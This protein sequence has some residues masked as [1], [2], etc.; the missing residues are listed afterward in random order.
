MNIAVTRRLPARALARLAELG[1]LWVWPQD[2]EMTRGELLTEALEAEVMVP[3][4]NNIMDAEVMT[5]RPALRLI[6]NY[7]VGYNNVDIEAAR[8]RGVMVANTPGVLTEA[9]ADLT[10]ALLLGAAR[11]VVEGDRLLRRG[12]FKGLAPEFHLGWDL[13]DRVLGIFGLGRIGAAVARRA[14]P[15]GLSIIYHNRKPNLVLEAE[16]GAQYVSFADLLAKS[17]FISINAPLTQETTHAFTMK[18]FKLM[19]PSAILIN[20]A[21]GP[22]V[23]EADLAEAL[24]TGVIAAAALDVYEF[25][26]QVE[27]RL[28]TLGNVVLCP[29]LGSATLEVRTRMGLIV[30]ENVAAFVAGQNPPYRVV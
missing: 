25:E 28:I 17:D 15:F 2:R 26:P 10:I 22:L 24:E 21:R 8:A 27:P 9:T 1:D 18:E 20:A 12:E 19:K 16:L 5:A 29:H 30:A 14:R 23:K 4:L 11:R 7:A 6:A 3:T 13:Q